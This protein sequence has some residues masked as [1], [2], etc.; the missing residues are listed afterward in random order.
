[1]ATL[2]Q[3]SSEAQETAA[4][5]AE[6]VS[7]LI[8]NSSDI[9]RYVQQNGDNV[10]LQTLDAERKKLLAFIEGS[11]I[12]SRKL[13]DYIGIL[14][15]AIHSAQQTQVVMPEPVPVKPTPKP[16]AATP[17]TSAPK[18]HIGNTGNVFA[19]DGED[20]DHGIGDN[21]LGLDLEG[22]LGDILSDSTSISAAFDTDQSDDAIRIDGDRIVL[23]IDEE[24]ENSIDEEAKMFETEQAYRAKDYFKALVVALALNIRFKQGV[25]KRADSIVNRQDEIIFESNYRIAYDYLEKAKASKGA[26]QTD[27]KLSA[28][29]HL[30]AS[31]DQRSRTGQEKLRDDMKTVIDKMVEKERAGAGSK[32]YMKTGMFSKVDVPTIDDKVSKSLYWNDKAK[33]EKDLVKR[34]YYM[35][36]AFAMDINYYRYQIALANFYIEINKLNEACR[37]INIPLP[38][39]ENDGIDFLISLQK[40]NSEY[41]NKFI[42]RRFASDLKQLRARLEQPDEKEL[43]EKDPVKKEN[44]TAARYKKFVDTIDLW[45]KRMDAMKSE[46]LFRKTT[47]RIEYTKAFIEMVDLANQTRPGAVIQDYINRYKGSDVRSMQ[48]PNIVNCIDFIFRYSITP[49]EKSVGGLAVEGDA[50]KKFEDLCKSLVDYF[51]IEIAASNKDLLDAKRMVGSNTETLMLSMKGLGY[52]FEKTPALTKK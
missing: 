28:I 22:V 35:L 49:D 42:E 47:L 18:E 6:L 9:E 30:Y 44:L 41:A 21:L 16:A 12:D 37:Y 51:N 52:K 13:K 45:Q 32:A 14:D 5:R 46:V 31:L 29:M 24:L 43:K 48:N 23:T 3:K 34:E 20:V 50:E 39:V 25:G 36:M 33:S 10:Y 2:T 27:Y 15:N 38:V 11:S 7:K 40:K 8:A 19:M 4:Q 17:A 1:M 26:E